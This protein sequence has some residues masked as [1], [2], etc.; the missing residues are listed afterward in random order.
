MQPEE[1]RRLA[2]GNARRALR[3]ALATGEPVL[4]VC[5][6][7]EAAALAAEEAAGV[8]L[9]EAPSGQNGAA[10]T[11]VAAA[12]ERG[13][14]ALLVVSSDL[15]L[16]TAA[17]LRAVIAAA[18]RAPRAAVA[19]AATGRGG[20]NALFMRPPGVIGL[21]FGDDSLARFERDAA[22]R[23]VGF[24]IVERPELALDL[25]EPTDLELLAEA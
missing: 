1:R 7:R 19:A 8:L 22:E 12:L 24:T 10:A 20:T 23:G 5:G 9:E 17:A 3:A 13:A 18:G 14:D 25:D 15:P 21:F 16:V 11:A 6:S 2:I 4:A